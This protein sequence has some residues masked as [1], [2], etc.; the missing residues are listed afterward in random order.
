VR[1]T[2]AK[3]KEKVNFPSSPPPLAPPPS[4]LSHSSPL[5]TFCKIATKTLCTAGYRN[6]EPVELAK[7]LSF[8]VG[9]AV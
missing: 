5:C 6:C 1:E 3:V 7:R 9:R 8:F 2:Y 4:T